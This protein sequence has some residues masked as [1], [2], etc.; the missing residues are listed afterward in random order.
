MDTTAPPPAPLPRRRRRWLWASLLLLGVLLGTVAGLI[1]LAWYGEPALPWL[2]GRVPGLK[3]EG[4]RGTMAGGDVTIDRVDWALPGAAGRLRI[5]GLRLEGIRWPSRYAL[6]VRR[7][8]AQRVQFDSAPSSGKPVTVPASLRLPL[9]LQVGELRVDTLRIDELPPLQKLQGALDLAGHLGGVH[10]LERFGVDWEAARVQG[11]LQIGSDGKLPLE[12]QL[13]AQSISGRAWRAQGSANGPLERLAVKLALE[14]EASAGAKPVAL[15]ADA[16][17]APFAPWPLAALT[18]TTQGFDLAALSPRLPSTSIEGSA[19][20]DSRGLDQP[21][22]AQIKLANGRPGRFDEAGLPL[23]G[24]VVTASGD[25]RQRD[26]IELQQFV[27]QLGDAK[28]GAGALRGSGRWADSRLVLDLQLDGVQPARLDGRAA[29]VRISGPLALQVDGLPAPG[30]S[31]PA[32]PVLAVKA[33]LNGQALDGT[34]QAVRLAFAGGGDGQRWKIDEA[35]ARAGKALARFSGEAQQESAGWRF[36]A[37]AQL[38]QF[39]PLPWWRGAEG[40]AWRRGPHLWNGTLKARG[41]WRGL[42]AGKDLLARWQRALDGDAELALAPSRLAGVALGGQLKASNRADGSRFDGTIDLAG[43]TLQAE[44]H[45]ARDPAADRWQL[46]ADAPALAALAPLSALLAP[47]AADWWPSAGQLQ[48][49]L[50]GEGRW[51]ALASSGQ[52]RARGLKS[53]AAALAEADLSWRHGAQATAPLS[54]QLKARGIEH[55]AQQVERLDA[56]A[57]GTLA[58]HTLRLSAASPLKPPAWSESLLGPAGSGTRLDA[59]GRG[60][61]SADAGGHRWQ[62][63][64]LRLRGGSRDNGSTEPWIAATD[65]GGDARFDANGRLLSL[66]LAPG[67]VQLLNTALRW[68]Q[69]DWRA[70]AASGG[71]ARLNVSGELETFDVAA[72]LK[73]LEPEF[74]WSGNLTLGGRVDIRSSDR[75]DADIVLERGGGDLGVTD[76]LGQTQVLGLT[77]LRLAF[78]AHDGVWQFA[79]GLAGRLIGEMAGAQVL[80]TT[81]ERSWPAADAPLQGVLQMRVANLGVWGTWVPPGWRLGGTLQTSASIGGRFNAPE[82]RGEMRGSQLAV[83]NLLEGVNLSDGELAITLEGERAEI[84]RLA[85]KGGDG[86]LTL[87]GSAT[88]G[89]EPSAQIALVAERFRLLGRIDR[90]IVTTGQADLRLDPKMLRLTGRFGVDEG[91]VDVSR[92]DAPTLDKDVQV[93]RNGATVPTGA[94]A[95]AVERERAA[96]ALPAPLRNAEVALAI[97][98]GE[99]LQLRGRGLDTGLRGSLRISA[100]GGRLAL[101]GSVRTVGGTYAAYGQKLEIARG[102]LFFSGAVD[103]PRLDVLAIRPNLDVVVGVSVIGTA[104]NPRIRLTSE[105]EMPEYDKLSWLVL[106]R[107]PDGL[108]RTDTALLQRAAVALLAGEGNSPTDDLINRLGLTDFSVRQTEG[109]VRETIV[110]LGKQLSRR[111]YVGYERSVNTTAGSW[112]LIYRIAQ[113]F[114]LRAQSGAESSLDLIWAWRWN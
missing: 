58:A 25:P 98:L 12:A 62:L 66:A 55:G 20:I 114:T 104:Q 100:P 107:G 41:L 56:Q 111:W 18:L 44:L 39:D 109:D 47:A 49:E 48:G 24:L 63:Q 14:G 75:F 59:E 103:N 61:W 105:P 82:L 110:S 9:A 70:A 106:G 33:T 54:L 113:R 65:L 87:T 71:S 50:R 80:R 38:D 84:K 96:R 26:R 43:N 46:R 101:N 40:S 28:N 64:A 37:D 42:P 73:R 15:Q 112:Q 57:D 52:L 7:A 8:T 91:L 1:A 89:A 93:T 88:L 3:V 2:L 86:R 6:S 97:E 31:T 90:R 102:E 22:A 53:R 94:A 19:V 99:R 95:R 83:R 16:Q 11:R 35:E 29:P 78:S 5:D 76:E 85:F 108:G 51:P 13:Q 92:A 34:G 36:A 81:P 10:K 17:I 27:L 68:R 30:S 79:Q 67:R 23:H 77:D 74:G 60:A 32:A 4:V 21:V 45:L 69:A 72:L